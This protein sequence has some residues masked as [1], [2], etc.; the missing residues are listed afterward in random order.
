MSTLRKTR[1]MGSAAGAALVLG[2]AGPAFAFQEVDWEWNKT[3]DELVIKRVNIEAEIN[4]TGMTEVEK[5]QIHIGDVNAT[6]DVRDVTNT[7]FREGGAG[8][9]VAISETF[10][11]NTLLDEGNNDIIEG[12]DLADGDDPA[13]GIEAQLVEGQ[14]SESGT[15]LD[16]TT[17]TFH[18]E[19]VVPFEFVGGESLDAALELPAVESAATAVGNN[20]QI[21]SEVAV[22]LH[23]GQYLFD[24]FGEN[25]GTGGGPSVPVIGSP[26]DDIDNGETQVDGGNN[27]LQDVA[28][29]LGIGAIA[30]V[31]D[32]A[33]ITATS[34][35]SGIV[36][37]TV[38]SSATAVGNNLSV[39]V[40]GTTTG[41][42]LLIGDVTQFAYA[43]VSATSMVSN[44]SVTGYHN[45]AAVSPIVSSTATAVGNNV[46]ISV[47][48]PSVGNAV[49]Q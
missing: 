37:A 42:A 11:V 19:G 32:R 3:V 2:L 45:L 38:D 1:L 43:D 49:T 26:G 48:S 27:Q 7:P 36:N 24:S 31:I 6:S 12:T 25:G 5:V 33:D 44:V 28:L 22:Q 21:T 39:E 34:T 18:I 41:D 30:G 16:P 40:N 10:E 29:L 15:A 13:N 17:L 23:D 46:S 35:V 14:V 9:G 20:Q 47:S 4:P 8:Q